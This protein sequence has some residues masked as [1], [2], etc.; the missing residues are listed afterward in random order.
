MNNEQV[1]YVDWCDG[2]YA[3]MYLNE[4]TTG[5]GIRFRGKLQEADTVNK[6]KRLYPRT[7]LES[8]VEKLTE[9]IKYRG[10]Y[11]ELDHASDSIVHL[12]NTSHLI[13]KLWWEDNVLMGEG[14]IL[15][16][17]N[18]KV[19]KGLMEVG[20]RIGMSSRGVGNGQVNN[21]GVLVIGESYKLITFDAVADPSTWEAF[22]KVVGKKESYR[23]TEKIS[24]KNES[25]CIHNLNANTLISY[26]GHIVQQRTRELKERLS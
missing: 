8:N 24:P 20:G 26:F 6:N 21:E 4:A 17:P 1:L 25:R 22:Q 13:T 10:L 19:L 15:N 14:E 23:N 3:E 18:G 7:V 16:T 11:G 2:G 9:A 5:G 12:A